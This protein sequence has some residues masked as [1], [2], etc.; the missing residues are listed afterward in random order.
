M[1][2]APDAVVLVTG[3]V[4]W[5]D[6]SPARGR[7]QDG[8]RPVVVVAGTAYLDV[9]D[10]LV[11]CV[12]LTTVDR[13]WSNHVPVAGPTGLAVPSWAMTEQVRTLSRGRLTRVAGQVD[14]A[15]LTQVRTWI[16]DFLELRLP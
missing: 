14:T 4:A 2:S 9:V 11:L 5:A 1:T 8:H 10:S 6:L 7:E 13:G 15:T 16:A 3:A 12:P